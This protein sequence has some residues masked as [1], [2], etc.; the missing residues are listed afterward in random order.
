MREHLKSQIDDSCKSIYESSKTKN[1]TDDLDKT[2]TIFFHLMKGAA[3]QKLVT[4]FSIK[5]AGR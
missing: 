3:L 1:N 2:E 4:L 5:W